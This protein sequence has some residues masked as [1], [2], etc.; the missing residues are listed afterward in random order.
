MIPKLF[1]SETWLLHDVIRA[2][3]KTSRRPSLVV[4][5]VSDQMRSMLK[6]A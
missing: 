6:T 2:M 5:R 1:L 3:Q 4:I